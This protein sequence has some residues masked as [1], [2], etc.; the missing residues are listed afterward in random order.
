MGSRR[1]PR[2]LGAL[3]LEALARSL[4]HFASQLQGCCVLACMDN[5]QAVFAINKG[6]SR[7][8]PLRHTLLE[9]AQ[10][11]LRWGFGVREKNTS[12]VSAPR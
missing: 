3:E 12:P 11:G 5:M 4:A 7:K 9:I 8:P 6:A 1:H 2:A 10:L